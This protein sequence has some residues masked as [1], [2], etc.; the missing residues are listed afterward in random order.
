M[1]KILLFTSLLWCLMS[2]SCSDEKDC[3]ICNT[4]I[5]AT[6]DSITCYYYS[7]H[8]VVSERQTTAT[9]KPIYEITGRLMMTPAL[10]GYNIMI[11]MPIERAK[12]DVTLDNVSIDPMNAIVW[13]EGSVHHVENLPTEGSHEYNDCL[14]ISVT[15]SNSFTVYYNGNS[16]MSKFNMPNVN[17]MVSPKVEYS[18]TFIGDE[19]V[20]WNYDT[21]NFNIPDKVAIKLVPNTFCI[22]YRPYYQTFIREF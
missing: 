4:N 1:K 22:N 3:P 12:V 6:P 21:E 15:S 9:Y 8:V 19:P 18:N 10:Y 13:D 16:G 20:K 14:S 7:G 17:I 11:P 2:I 5:N